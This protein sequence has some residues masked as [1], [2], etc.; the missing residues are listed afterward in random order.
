MWRRSQYISKEEITIAKESFDLKENYLNWADDLEETYEDEIRNK[1]RAAKENKRLARSKTGRGRTLL[2]YDY[3]TR[4]ER[5]KLREGGKVVVWNMNEII[6]IVEFENM[7]EDK[8][9]E[10][11]EYWRTKYTNKEIEQ[12]MG[13]SSNKLS[14]ML[15]KL[16]VSKKPRGGANAQAATRQLS[17]EELEDFKENLVD[18]QTL[19]SIITKQRYQIILH[20]YDELEMQ[21]SEIAEKIDTEVKNVYS[22]KYQADKWAI[23]NGLKEDPK[24]EMKRQQ[25]EVQAR[26]QEQQSLLSQAKDGATI[27]EPEQADQKESQNSELQPT[28]QSDSK[29]QRIRELEQ[30]LEHKQRQIEIKDK[31]LN[32]AAPQSPQYSDGLNFYIQGEFDSETATRRMNKVSSMIADEPGR[33]TVRLLVQELEQPKQ[34]EQAEESNEE[35]INKLRQALGGNL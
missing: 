12:A 21:P 29:D 23:R 35:F 13:I 18:W 2:S 16:G 3:L 31:Q 10:R 20:W 9:K 33:F 32:L 7:P 5:K 11:L 8:Q 19:K 15:S 30:Q 28:A 34:V 17:E 14:K 1:A 26:L 24:E 4:A 27:E 6:H 25:E 22:T